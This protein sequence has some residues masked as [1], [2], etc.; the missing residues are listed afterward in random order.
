[1]ESPLFPESLNGWKYVCVF[2]DLLLC[3]NKNNA[4]G[5]WCIMVRCPRL[6]GALNLPVGPFIPQNVYTPHL[7]LRYGKSWRLQFPRLI[8]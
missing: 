3:R 7:M 1:M 5:K 8:R 2:V 6:C 4:T